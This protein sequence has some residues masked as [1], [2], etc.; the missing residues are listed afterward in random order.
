VKPMIKQGT[1]KSTFAKNALIAYYKDRFFQTVLKVDLTN[2]ED[3][4]ETNIRYNKFYTY[5][6]DKQIEE[7][8]N[9]GVAIS[10]VILKSGVICTCYKHKTKYFGRA[11]LPDDQRGATVKGTYA[12]KLELG[13]SFP[14]TRQQLMQDAFVN[15]HGLAL[16][17]PSVH[18]KVNC[19]DVSQVSN[20]HVY[21]IVLD[22]WRER[23]FDKSKNEALYIL[24]RINGCKY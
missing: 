23:F 16:P 19:L 2:E 8:L 11:L 6:S 24:P 1:H 9:S 15:A 13:N 22:S 14:V 12:T 7:N 10:I 17:L 4:E 3:G 21:Y 5:R 20:G 18:A